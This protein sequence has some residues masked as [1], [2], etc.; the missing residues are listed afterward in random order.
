MKGCLER[1]VIL[2]R[3]ATGEGSLRILIGKFHRVSFLF[4]A[5]MS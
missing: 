1:A 3:N 2:M 5:G 4:E